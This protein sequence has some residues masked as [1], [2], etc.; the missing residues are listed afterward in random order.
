M[1][2]N[3]KIKTFF[4][5]F[6]MAIQLFISSFIVYV[7][8]VFVFPLEYTIIAIKISYIIGVVLGIG[9]MKY[10]EKFIK[11]KLHFILVGDSKI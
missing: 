3:K 11:R 4:F 7:Y 2:V 1:K 5:F 6:W 8:G 9:M 10:W